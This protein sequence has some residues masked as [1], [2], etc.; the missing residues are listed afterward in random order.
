MLAPGVNGRFGNR[1][2]PYTSGGSVGKPVSKYPGGLQVV[3]NR[4]IRSSE[5]RSFSSVSVVYD[6]NLVGVRCGVRAKEVVD[7]IS[8]PT[9]L[10]LADI[11]DVVKEF[12]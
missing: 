9:S 1:L 7:A 8:T 2:N 5:D 12:C 11:G 3:N 6:R 4:A 10:V